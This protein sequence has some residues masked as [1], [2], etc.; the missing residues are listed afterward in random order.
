MFEFTFEKHVKPNRIKTWEKS[1]VD[2]GKSYVKGM[3]MSMTL[4]T[5]ETKATVRRIAT[6]HVAH[7]LAHTDVIK[8]PLNPGPRTAQQWAAPRVPL[9]MVLKSVDGDPSPAHLWI[10]LSTE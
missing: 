3:G 10:T 5:E 9:S 1:I 4:A 7:S 8:S 6:C 2:G